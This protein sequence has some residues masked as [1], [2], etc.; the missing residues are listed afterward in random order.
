MTRR[1]RFIS[2]EGGEGVG[3]TSS[4]DCISGWLGDRGIEVVITREPGG[5]ALG[6]RLRELILGYDDLAAEAELL[7]IFAARAQHAREVIAPALAAG[8]WV[9]SDRFTD[10][11][12]AYQGGGRGI[13][14]GMI[15]ALEEWTVGT[16]EP[17][18]TFLLDAPVETGLARARTRG[19]MDRFESAGRPFLQRVRQAYLDRAGNCPQRIV[20]IDAG[21]SR[22]SVRRDIQAHLQGRFA[23]EL[24]HRR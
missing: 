16:L 21:R 9:L 18:L 1:G 5:T 4:L 24:G 13:A 15:R 10:A 7:L 19:E 2:L 6:E 17:D 22:E 23:H 12:Y 20:V 8:R 14:V 11:S 3:K